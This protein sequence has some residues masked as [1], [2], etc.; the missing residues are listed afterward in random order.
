MLIRHVLSLVGLFVFSCAFAQAKDEFIVLSY[1]DIK[2]TISE[3]LASAQTAVS[4]ANLIR[5][6]DWLKQE[7]Y[8][9]ISVQDLLEARAGKKPLPDKSVLLTFDDGYASFYHKV[10]PLL[11]QYG[12]PALVA[13]VGSWLEPGNSSASGE[14]LPKDSLLSWAQLQEISR[15]NLVEI[16]S[17]SYDLHHGILGNPQGNLQPAGTTRLYDAASKTYESDAAYVKRV[18]AEMRKASDQLFQ[19]VGVRPK[20]MVWPYGEANQVLIQAAKEVGMTLTLGLRDGYNSLNDMSYAGRLL[21][22]NNPAIDEFAKLVLRLRT[23]DRPL[24]VVHVDMDFIYDPDPAQTER[25]LGRLL[26]RIQAMRVNTV[27]LQA[28]SDPDGDGNAD[29][30]YF[31]NRHLPMRADLFNRV[32]WQLLTRTRVKVYA[33]MPVLA[34]RIKAPDSW[35]VHEW[36]DGKPLLARHIYKR[37]SP[38]NPDAKRVVGEIY[39]DLAKH[40]NFAGLLFHDDAILSDYEDVSPRA[41]KIVKQQWSLPTEENKLRGV[42]AMRMKWAKHKTQALIEWTRYLADKVRYYRLD[43][44]TARNYYAL[45]ILK[46]DSE[47]WYA[48]SLA[49]GLAAYDYVAIEAMPFM[50]E[51]E[52]PDAW[53]EELVRKVASQ[54]EGLRKTVFELQTVDWRTQKKIPMETFLK[55]LRLVQSLGGGHLGYYPDNLFEDQPRQEDMEKAFALP[56]F[57]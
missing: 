20:V 43:T 21:I 50:E 49:T 41:M 31:P 35:F 25:N 57:P 2:D 28:F 17:H 8:R 22:T 1:H 12:Y 23:G 32:A 47:E 33:W 54:P 3:D 6:F 38:F 18:R 19:H 11:K 46:P 16:A 27:Y 37:L 42:A 13:V 39:E 15:S 44:K 51:A 56:R 7:A 40:C 9:V 14:A 29:S 53:L 34:F 24:H 5:Q 4:T 55:Q 26:D 52:N 48:Q 30:L 10:F 36:R 45:P